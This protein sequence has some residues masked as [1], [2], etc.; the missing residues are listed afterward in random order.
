MENCLDKAK[1]TS[2]EGVQV[3]RHS[4][5]RE[6][7]TGIIFIP[8]AVALS[9]LLRLAKLSEQSAHDWLMLHLEFVGLIVV[10]SA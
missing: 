4:Q 10:I 9:P 8:D 3:H 7:A 2:A 6:Q 1:F 5:H